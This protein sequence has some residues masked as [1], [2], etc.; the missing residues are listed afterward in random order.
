MQILVLEYAPMAGIDLVSEDPQV[1]GKQGPER[2]VGDLVGQK[3]FADLRLMG[4]KQI[5]VLRSYVTN[6]LV[7]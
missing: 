7:L 6:E 5:D 4:G 3:P 2:I 1:L